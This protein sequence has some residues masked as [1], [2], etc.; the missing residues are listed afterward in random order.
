[1]ELEVDDLLITL[2]RKVVIN[3]TGLKVRRA[4]SQHS[5]SNRDETLTHV[6]DTISLHI[7]MKCIEEVECGF[8]F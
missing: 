2:V 6:W 5:C 1:M 3:I 8:K 7:N 4:E